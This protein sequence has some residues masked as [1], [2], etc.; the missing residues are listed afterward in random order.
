[1]RRQVMDI[2]MR[3]AQASGYP[4]PPLVDFKLDSRV[5]GSGAVLA[6]GYVNVVRCDAELIFLQDC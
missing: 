2:G 6:P 5:T 3:S 4:I 1:M